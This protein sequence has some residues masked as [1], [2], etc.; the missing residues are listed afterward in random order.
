MADILILLAESLMSVFDKMLASVGIGSAKVD[1]RLNHTTLRVGESLEGEVNI[2][3]GS[4]EQQIDGIYL[5]LMTQYSKEQGDNT[6]Y[7]NFTLEKYEVS[8][9]ITI[10]PGQQVDV[11]ITLRLPLTT[12]V[13]MGRV[14]VWLKTGLDID[15]AI[16][17]KDTDRLEILPHRNMER[18]LNAVTHMGFRLKTS[19]CEYSSRLGQGVPFVQEIEF[20]PPP[21]YGIGIREL[22]LMFFLQP[23]GLEVVVEVDRRGRGLGGLMERA[24][25]MDDRRHRLRFSEEELGRGR[26]FIAQQLSTTISQ[27]AG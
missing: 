2:R 24:L 20:H 17:P 4:T 15:N 11:P 27:L 21:S 22:E 25:D 13:T 14:P 5:H 10:A 7:I 8:K 23:K 19:T 12:P 6:S 18:V 16:D 3:G 26:D 1:T 9:P